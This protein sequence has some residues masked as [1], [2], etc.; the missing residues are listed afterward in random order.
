MFKDLKL[1]KQLNTP[2]QTTTPREPINDQSWS[3]TDSDTGSDLEEPTMYDTVNFNSIENLH[4]S[5]NQCS[6][7]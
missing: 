5:T 2:E 6:M 4:Q 1:N 7:F 3:D